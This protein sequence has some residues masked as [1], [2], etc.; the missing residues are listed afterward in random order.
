MED[1]KINNRNLYERKRRNHE[2]DHDQEVEHKK[3]WE[4]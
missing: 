1:D 4:K 2:V 3:I